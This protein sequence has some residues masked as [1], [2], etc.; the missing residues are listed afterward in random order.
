MSGGG[1]RTTP[2][3][4]TQFAVPPPPFGMV[5]RPRLS[6]RVH[7]GL[8][9]PVTLICA[10][11]GSGKTALIAS[12]VPDA[13]WITLEAADDEPGRLWG[14]VLTA[15][16]IAGAVPADSSL[17]ALAAPVRDSRDTFMPL[18]V[19]ALAEIPRRV[20]LVLDD[21]HVL[22]SRECLAQLA[23]LLLHT[24][25]TLRVVLTARSD[26]RVPLHVLRVRG[27]LA[28]IRASDLAFTEEK[29]EQLLA[30]HGLALTPP[31]VKALHARTEGWSAGLR[32][33]ALSLQGRDDPDAFI[34]EFA[35]DDRVVGDY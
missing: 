28:E 29:S 9:E 11:A 23:F 24:P 27:R 22:R 7:R 6:E 25:D 13:A 3:L 18:L 21:V 31:Q 35:G 26:P 30:A 20:V 16:E 15:L 4:V 19:N 14:A 17:A 12:Q 2:T 8:E 1:V 32:L 5:D 10:P 34:A 33:A